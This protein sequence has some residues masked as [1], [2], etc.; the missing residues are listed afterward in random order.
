LDI[1]C[2]CH[3]YTEPKILG[4]GTDVAWPA[5]WDQSQADAWRQAQGLTPLIS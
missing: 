2:E 5:G 4:N 1:F 3:R